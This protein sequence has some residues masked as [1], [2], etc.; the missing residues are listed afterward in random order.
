MYVCTNSPH[1]GWTFK[2]LKGW[3]YGDSA[4]KWRLEHGDMLPQQEIHHLGNLGIYRKSMN[5]RL[6]FFFIFGLSNKDSEWRD[7]MGGCRRQSR[8]SI[9]WS[10][11]WPATALGRGVI[12]QE[13]WMLDDTYMGLTEN[14]ENPW[15]SDFMIWHFKYWKWFSNINSLDTLFEPIGFVRTD[16]Q[17][18]WKDGWEKS[19][20]RTVPKNMRCLGMLASSR[21]CKQETTESHVG[22]YP[23]N[24]GYNTNYQRP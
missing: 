6:F 16:H 8:N 24:Y 1:Q 17:N 12:V 4:M 21:D 11:R 9:F 14:G 5:I 22:L 20:H 3:S 18:H 15:K 7:S 13:A 19:V 2:L 10:S 23:P